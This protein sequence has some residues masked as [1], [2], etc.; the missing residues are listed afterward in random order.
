M[1]LSTRGRYGLR[2]MIELADRRDFSRPVRTE[3]L[4]KR[5]AI[6]L[7]YLHHLL[8]QLRAAGLINAMHGRRGGYVLARL[9]ET[10]TALDV[11]RAVEGPIAPVDC[12]LEE[13]HC[14]RAPGCAARELWVELAGE[15]ERV[16]ASA[17]LDRLARRQEAS[18]PDSTSYEI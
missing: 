17:T 5:Q 9:P 6:P 15:M 11:L 13:R 3:T 14:R 4:A 16:L 8:A 18:R 10:I 2:V 1:K 7:P 12:V